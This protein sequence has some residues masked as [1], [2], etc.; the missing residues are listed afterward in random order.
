MKTWLVA[1]NRRAEL[2]DYMDQRRHEGSHMRTEVIDGT[3]RALLPF[4]DD[5]RLAVPRELYTLSDAET[6]L[7]TSLRSFRATEDGALEI[8]GWAYIRYVDLSA[9]E[10][11]LRAWLINE[12]GERRELAV[13]P[14]TSPAATRWGGHRYQKLRPGGFAARID[15]AELAAPVPGDARSGTAARW[16]VEVSVTVNGLERTGVINHRDIR[17]SAGYL[18]AVSA[19]TTRVVPLMV[20]GEGLVLEVRRP[21]VVLNDISFEDRTVRGTLRAQPTDSLTTLVATNCS[22]DTVSTRLKD[23]DGLL[24]FE[25]ELPDPDWGTHALD[26]RFWTLQASASGGRR[27][28]RVSWPDDDRTQWRGTAPGASLAALRTERHNVELREVAC[29]PVIDD[30]DLADGRILMRGHWVGGVPQ[31]WHPVLASARMTVTPTLVATPGQGLF[32]VTFPVEVDE[33]GAGS[34]PLPPG[35][36]S[37]RVDLAPTAEDVPGAVLPRMG[38][39]LIQRTTVDALS[40][41][42]RLQLRRGPMNHILLVASAPLGDEVVSNRAQACL[43]RWY[44]E[45]DIPAEPDA[46]LFQCYRGETATDSQLALHTELR[47]RAWSGPLYWGVSDYSVAVPDGGIPVLM[48]S[49]EWYTKLAAAGHLV[50]NIDFDRF[51]VKRGHQRFLQTFHGYPFKSMGIAVWSKTATEARIA[52]EVARRNEAWDVILTPT[53]EMNE[54]YRREYRYTGTILDVG[55]PRNDALVDEHADQTRKSTREILGVAEHQTVV[56]YA[57]TWR[58]TLATGTWSARLPNYLDFAAAS[59]ALGEDFVLLMRGHNFNARTDARTQRTARVIDVT[60]YPQINDLVLASDA[61]V[62]DYSSLRFDYAL[63]GKPMVFLVPDLYSY[64]GAE[65][66]FLFDYADTAPGPLLQT[67]AEVVAALQDLAGVREEHA[68]ATRRSTPRTTTCMTATPP[69]ASPMRSS[70]GSSRS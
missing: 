70:G 20:A 56:M 47:R 15:V 2:I 7:V 9:S 25:L 36:Y 5:A 61:A 12:Q 37:L 10:P 4:H 33:W 53:P 50:N 28:Q 38:E 3:V 26:R 1:E 22:G 13:H 16:R 17:S 68:A 35:T 49:E 23:Q 29:Y 59:E 34:L 6:A 65:R 48:R 46:V 30:V 52:Q 24:G 69:S 62:L 55:Y 66:G 58:D 42:L 19:G 39:A 31:T 67:T 57:P 41:R 64:G 18:P 11:T 63:T 27:K 45:S 51:F 14:F 40:D 8:E 43:Q 21:H 60:D 54:H 32:E 44:A